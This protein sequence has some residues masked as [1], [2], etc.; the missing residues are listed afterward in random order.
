MAYEFKKLSDVNAI[1]GMKEN[2]NVLVED[3]GEIV[4]LAANSMIPEDVALK[5]DI[6]TGVVK[7]INGEVPDE[8]GN[9]Q[10]SGL[11][12]GAQSH[13][14]L[15]TDGKGKAKWEDRYGYRKERDKI[16]LV[17]NGS[18]MTFYHVS[19][20]APD[21]PDAGTCRVWHESG[22]A[23]A[24]PVLLSTSN[25]A[26]LSTV[27]IAYSDNV[28]EY[29]GDIPIYAPK[30]GMYFSIS[31]P[32]G[33]IVGFSLSSSSEMPEYTWDGDN[34]IIVPIPAEYLPEGVGSGGG[35]TTFYANDDYTSDYLYKDA[36]RTIKV[37]HDEL[38]AAANTS[39]IIVRWANEYQ[40][41]YCY[42]TA[43]VDNVDD[44]ACVE[45]TLFS[46]KR[47]AYTAEWEPS[48][49]PQ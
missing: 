13:Q 11:P 37:T 8:N 48:S 4:K 6:P 40:A 5:S 42:P 14:Q 25:M 34:T 35:F 19:A 21:L 26:I 49:G 28:T 39:L 15:V 12:E 32:A 29:V 36:E 38:I 16:V 10:V 18:A 7:S 23:E 17:E 41:A 22:Y 20:D 30:K 2:L 31:H 3:N 24:A 27:L 33:K 44:W 47:E 9:V 1:E 45:F 43:V 46:N